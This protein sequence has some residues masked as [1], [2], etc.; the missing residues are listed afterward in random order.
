[1]II[2]RCENL[3]IVTFVLANA[4]T[5]LALIF[6]A[7]SIVR[8]QAMKER[9]DYFIVGTMVNVTFSIIM[10]FLIKFLVII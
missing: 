4:Y 5:A 9:A 1:M 10:G 2:G 3:L 6:A 8:S 7:K